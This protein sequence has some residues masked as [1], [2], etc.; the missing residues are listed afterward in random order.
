MIL[1]IPFIAYLVVLFSM[2]LLSNQVLKNRSAEKRK[3]NRKRIII[4]G[5]ILLPVFGFMYFLSLLSG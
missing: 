2:I 3:K 1:L 5:S 4:F